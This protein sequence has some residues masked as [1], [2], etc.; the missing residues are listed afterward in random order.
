MPKRF[1]YFML[2]A[3]LPVLAKTSIY[4]RNPGTG[5]ESWEMRLQGMSLKFAQT[6]PDQVRGFYAAN[7]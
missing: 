1:A 4:Q 3:S 5:A 7:A 2:L 6:L